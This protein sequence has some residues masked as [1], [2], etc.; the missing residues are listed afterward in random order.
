MLNK[1][2]KPENRDVTFEIFKVVYSFL[3]ENANVLASEII[4]RRNFEDEISI[5]TL[6]V[7]S[8]TI[9]NEDLRD[10]LLH[11]EVAVTTSPW[12][13]WEQ[14]IKNQIRSV[15]LEALGKIAFRS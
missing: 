2:Y 1:P 10:I 6:E 5:G 14:T 4:L 15:C 11:F 9:P 8:L 7:E 3:G 13:V 12:E